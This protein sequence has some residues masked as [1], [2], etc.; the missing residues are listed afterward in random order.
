MHLPSSPRFERI[1]N[2]GRQCWNNTRPGGQKTWRTCM[3]YMENLPQ[4]SRGMSALI[5]WLSTS[6]SD[7]KAESRVSKLVNQLKHNSTIEQDWQ[8]PWI[9]LF[10]RSSHAAI[11]TYALHRHLKPGMHPA[12]PWGKDSAPSPQKQHPETDIQHTSDK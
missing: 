4:G 12:D 2:T 9:H 3:E 6:T 11:T 7:R 1:A 10:H 8:L 5:I